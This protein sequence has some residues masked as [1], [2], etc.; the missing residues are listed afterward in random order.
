MVEITVLLPFVAMLGLAALG[1]P[2]FSALGVGLIL[3]AQLNPIMN[4]PFF[5]TTLFES[6]NKVALIAIP[7]FILTGD[8]FVE[9][10]LSEK[11]LNFARAF[12][13]GIRSGLG[14][15]VVLGCG[16]FATIS[17]SNAAD[18]A[19][20]GRIT[21]DPLEKAGYPRSYSSAMIAAGATTGILI[22][23]SIAYIVTGVAIGV[24]ASDLFLAAFIPGTIFLFG[25][26][27]TN[28]FVDY[29]KGYEKTRI[30]LSSIRE[31]FA[32]IW[33]AKGAIAV[34]IV[35]L[36]GI[37]SG[38][39]TPTESAA[40]AI[41]TILVVGFVRGT[42]TL[43]QIPPTF[44]RSAAV[45]GTIGPII[46]FA[47][48]LGQT[49]AILR[50]PQAITELLTGLTS[51][52]AVLILLM[53]GLLLGVGAFIEAGPSILILGPLLLPLATSAGM[54]TIHYAVFLNMSLA[55]GFITPPFGLNLFVLSGVSGE[56]V[57]PIAQH[58]V[59]FVVGMIIVVLLIAF[60]PPLTMWAFS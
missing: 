56:G 4:P 17:G 26:V 25:V 24:P 29:R 23:P 42:M 40:V 28:F 7:L 5:S 1:V 38:I 54:D 47:L 39:F 53:F 31:R 22:P 45:N 52:N 36:G 33:E 27:A 57:L 34:P 59:Y 55:I 58:A 12:L 6:L 13:G 35:L 46:A 3:F 50:I 19:A 21:L 20:I 9:T 14:T 37:Y 49:F 15:S 2:I 44:Q 43:A 60:Y 10:G 16:F 41:M 11:L 30:E 8:V 48:I 18:A 32:A 51:I